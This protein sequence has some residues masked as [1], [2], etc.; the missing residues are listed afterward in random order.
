MSLRSCRVIITDLEGVKH[1]AHVTASS[2]YEA[3]ALGLT[4]VR[5]SEWAGKIA[6][7]LNTIEVV[8][9][10][11]PVTHSVTMQGF[12]AWLARTARTPKEL[13]RLQ[14][15]RSLLGIADKAGR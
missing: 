1:T 4:T 13:A 9:A 15:I 6:A 5:D 14:H 7:G 8:V 10:S 12:Q 3:V 11:V 2:L